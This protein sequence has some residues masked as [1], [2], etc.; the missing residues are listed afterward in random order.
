MSGELTVRLLAIESLA[1]WQTILFEREHRPHDPR[2][3]GSGVPTFLELSLNLVGEWMGED[4]PLASEG[5]IKLD[6]GVV[7]GDQNSGEK[8][9]KPSGPG[10]SISG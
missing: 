9:T 5:P 6:H 10:Y 4:A 2:K 1:K 3:G 7:L 8:T